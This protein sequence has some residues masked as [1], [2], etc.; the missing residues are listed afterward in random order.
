LSSVFSTGSKDKWG[1]K[2]TNP[3]NWTCS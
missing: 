3:Q 1:T 2:E